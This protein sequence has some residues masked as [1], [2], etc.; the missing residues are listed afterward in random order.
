MVSWFSRNQTSVALST[1]D[2]KYIEV[3]STCSEAVW[4]Q[5]LL[6]GLFDLELEVTCI[7]FDNQSCVKF[8]ENPVFHENSKDIDIKYN[9]VRD[10]VQRRAMKL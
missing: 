6:V 3:C 8:S 4:H 9:Y 5:K 1:V 7:W 10:M 2:A